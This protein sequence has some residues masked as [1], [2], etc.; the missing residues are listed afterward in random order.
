MSGGSYEVVP[1][2]ALEKILPAKTE[3]QLVSD[4]TCTGEE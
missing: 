2:K 1:I 4:P 3:V